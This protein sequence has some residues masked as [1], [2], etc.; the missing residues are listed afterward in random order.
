MRPSDTSLALSLSPASPLDAWAAPFMLDGAGRGGDPGTGRW[1]HGHPLRAGS[2]Q[3]D[4]RAGECRGPLAPGTGWHGPEPDRGPGRAGSAGAGGHARCAPAPVRAR[5]ACRRGPCRPAPADRCRPDHF[6]AVHRRCHGRGPGID[7]ERAGAGGGLGLR[8]HGRRP[9][10]PVPGGLCRGAGAGAGR[11]G[12]PD[13]G[14]T[15]LP[16]CPDALRRRQPG[17]AGT[18]PLRRHHGQLRRPL[19]PSGAVGAAGRRRADHPAHGPAR[20]HPGADPGPQDRRGQPDRP[21]D[22]GGL[23]AAAL[24]FGPRKD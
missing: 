10:R 6:P 20:C 3:L 14:G 17:L 7:R 4:R 11:A 19:H 23:R 15:W 8:L 1:D 5:P 9:V 22:G 16:Q 2:W 21:A 18:R 24:A 12:G 13:A